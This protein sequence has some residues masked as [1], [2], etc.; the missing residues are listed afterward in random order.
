[1]TYKGRETEPVLPVKAL[2]RPAIALLAC[3]LLSLRPA[4]VLL[5]PVPLPRHRALRLVLLSQV[6]HRA[7]IKASAPRVVYP[8]R[9]A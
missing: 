5:A 6:A 1:M 4:I 7:G 8:R 9:Q 2:L 3:V